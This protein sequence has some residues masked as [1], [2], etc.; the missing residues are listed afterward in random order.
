[1]DKPST[2]HGH[3]L[4]DVAR[5]LAGIR[6]GLLAILLLVV[7]GCI[8]GP[9]RS[10]LNGRFN[11]LTVETARCA[12]WYTYPLSLPAAAVGDTG[13]LLVDTLAVPS[14]TLGSI[15]KETGPFFFLF[16]LPFYPI[17]C[18]SM[19]VSS[20]D[21]SVGSGI[22]Y[23]KLFGYRY[24]DTNIGRLKIASAVDSSGMPKTT[25]ELDGRTIG[26][27]SGDLK[28]TALATEK[29]NLAIGLNDGTIRWWRFA[30]GDWSLKAGHF[31]PD[32]QEVLTAIN[33]NLKRANLPLS[34][35]QYENL[36]EMKSPNLMELFSDT[37]PEQYKNLV[38]MK[39]QLEAGQ[40]LTFS[41]M[42]LTFI[43]GGMGDKEEPLIQIRYSL[44]VTGQSHWFIGNSQTDG[45]T[46]HF[47]VGYVSSE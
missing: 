38:E 19:M 5:A 34:P 2:I 4:R 40:P 6:S 10:H 30:D 14:S 28:I 24:I 29:D 7:S 35:E 1:M 36:V 13:I 44:S 42:N 20:G 8:N 18:Y 9:M 12:P 21:S 3:G 25:I 11:Y 27:F 41:C 45:M 17:G 16:A 37:S 47:W 22:L 46:L 33:A 39:Q 23:E 15:L 32:R 26:D 31:V 43:H